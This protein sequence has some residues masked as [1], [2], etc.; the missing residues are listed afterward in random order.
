VLGRA[1]LNSCR[2]YIALVPHQF[3]DNHAKVMWALS[4]MK[5]RC[6]AQFIDHHMHCYQMI[7]SLS[8]LSWQEFAEEFAAEF[9]LENKIQTLRTELETSR[10]FQGSQMVNEYVNEFH[11]MI[12]QANYFEG[13]HIVLKF[14]DHVVRVRSES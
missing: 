1:F 5:G 9:C 6:A 14:Q 4:F 3:A 10:C 8:Y 2:L 13:S 11:K 7:G 12:K